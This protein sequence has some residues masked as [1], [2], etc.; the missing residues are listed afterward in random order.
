MSRVPGG[1]AMKRAVA[2]E[3]ELTLN[4]VSR[5]LLYRIGGF[6]AW[7]Y[8]ALVALAIALLFIA[9]VPP[10]GGTALLTYVADHRAVYI[11]E[12]ACFVGLAVPG[13]IAF[14]ALAVALWDADRSLALLGGVLGVASETAALA[15]GG[16][17]QSLHGGV[18]LLADAYAAATDPATRTALVGA[19]DALASAVN[20]APWAGILTAAAIGV[21]S[22]L[23]GRGGLGRAFGAVG[24]ATGVLGIV[25]EAVRPLIGPAYLLYGLLLPLWF[26]QVGVRLLRLAGQPSGAAL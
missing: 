26:A 12:L 25:S 6:A 3:G 23:V 18:M 11:V 19:A 24:L 8:V 2:I 4:P 9:P 1:R 13:L 22:L 7:A 16:S 17:P 20:G 10:A 5:R 15:V 21:L 14:A